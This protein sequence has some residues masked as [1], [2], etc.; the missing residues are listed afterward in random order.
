MH[1]LSPSPRTLIHVAQRIHFGM[2][3]ATIGDKTVFRACSIVVVASGHYSP[4]HDCH[5]AMLHG[6][7]RTERFEPRFFE[8]FQVAATDLLWHF[9]VY[10]YELT[11]IFLYQFHRELI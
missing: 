1:V 6:N 10:L 11:P 4:V 8:K 7:R 5:A 9:W 3:R 2:T